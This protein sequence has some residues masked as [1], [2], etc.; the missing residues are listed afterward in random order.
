[1]KYFPTLKNQILTNLTLAIIPTAIFIKFAI[2]FLRTYH[3]LFCK[4]NISSLSYSVT[5]PNIISLSYQHQGSTIPLNTSIK[6]IHITTQSA[7]DTF[8]DQKFISTFAS[9][10]IFLKRRQEIKFESNLKIT[11]L[12]KQNVLNFLKK[13]NHLHFTI[14]CKVILHLFSF[15]FSFNKESTFSIPPP[16]SEQKGTYKVTEICLKNVINLDNPS[17][18]PQKVVT[19][20]D[21]TDIYQQKIINFDDFLTQKNTTPAKSDNTK[22]MTEESERSDKNPNITQNQP[23]NT[24]NLTAECLTS[25]KTSNTTQNQSTK[26]QTENNTTVKTPNTIQISISPNNLQFSPFISLYLQPLCITIN[27]TPLFTSNITI[28]KGVLHPFKIYI[29][30]ISY[31]ISLSII[32]GVLFKRLI[33]NSIKGTLN[34]TIKTLFNNTDITHMI[35]NNTSNTTKRNN[36]N[37][38]YKIPNIR[39]NLHSIKD[40]NI[41]FSTFIHNNIIPL[42]I[43]LITNTVLPPIKYIYGNKN[44]TSNCTY[45]YIYCKDSIKDML[46]S[47]KSNDYKGVNIVEDRLE[48][49]NI[50]EDRLE[51]VNNKDRSEGVSNTSTKQ[52]GVSNKSNE[53]HPVITNTNKQHPVITNTN[54]QHPVINTDI[55]TT[56]FNSV[57]GIGT[58]QVLLYKQGIKINTYL[59]VYSFE[60]LIKKLN[61]PIIIQPICDTPLSLLLSVMS[62]IYKDKTL[63]MFNKPIAS[64]KGNNYIENGNGREIPLVD[65]S[66]VNTPLVEGCVNNTP[67]TDNTGNNTP[68]TDSTGNNT[69]L[70]DSTGYNTPLTDSTDN[71]TPLVDSDVNNTNNHI[72]NNHTNNH[73]NTTTT[74][75]SNT[76][77][78]INNTLYLRTVINIRNNPNIIFTSKNFNIKIYINYFIFTITLRKGII[79]LNK[80]LIYLN[81]KIERNTTTVKYPL[82]NINTGYTSRITYEYVTGVNNKYSDY[83]GVNNSRDDYKGVNNTIN[84][85]SEQQGVNYSSSE[86]QGVNN[87]INSTNE[88]QGV[89]NTINSTNEQQGVNN[90]TT[91]TFID[92]LSQLLDYCNL[93]LIGIE[94]INN[95]IFK[96]CTDTHINNKLK[97]IFNFNKN[98]PNIIFTVNIPSLRFSIEGTEGVICSSGGKVENRVGDVIICNSSNGGV[99]DRDGLEGVNNTT[100]NYKDIKGVSNKD[101]LEGVNNTTNKQQGVS[102]SSNE[103]QSVNNTTNKQQGVSNST[104]KQQG[105]SNS[106]SKQ[107]GVNQSTNKQN[108][109]NTTTN[110]YHPLN[111]TTNKQNPLN[112]T[113]TNSNKKRGVI[114]DTTD[115]DST[116]TISIS[117]NRIKRLKK[118]IIRNKKNKNRS[119]YINRDSSKYISRDSSMYNNNEVYN[120]TNNNSTTKTI[121]TNTSTLAVINTDPLKLLIGCTNNRYWINRKCV[122]GVIRINIIDY[123]KLKG[124]NYISINSLSN[125]SSVSKCIEALFKNMYILV[126]GVNDKDV[127]E[128]DSNSSYEQQGVSNSRIVIIRVL[129]TVV[130]NNRVLVTILINNTPLLPVLINNTPLPL[131]LLPLLHLTIMYVMTVTIIFIKQNIL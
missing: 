37:T 72:N 131:P 129:I 45:D 35:P 123:S 11:S 79:D 51:G 89:N 39:F 127:L 126:K 25:D 49:V 12:N 64:I 10:N 108:P 38:Y 65:S 122:M 100:S 26:T 112:T 116:N 70:T 80:G 75:I 83:R 19:L 28:T 125:S 110:T 6:D 58:L 14:K 120:T 4:Y 92:I 90:T 30:F 94:D 52:H 62:V 77:T 55:L 101:R 67:L 130:M 7:S 121:L 102:N 85:N 82:V 59:T 9:S 118:R 1:M 98:V 103:Q 29:P 105:V 50:V 74:L 114:Y 87:T 111:T 73:T 20:I 33:I 3:L 95:L 18:T 107:Q 97:E 41:V 46:E 53:Q 34:N 69:P 54:K 104:S 5:Q 109:V 40:N 43:S 23:L 128:G 48:G 61:T 106:T 42:D 17:L 27:N 2:V 124:F 81:T 99:N 47:D 24:N 31:K 76:F 8:T 71:N 68:L 63:Y 60:L 32:K 56:P 113:T 91:N 117:K 93:K 21:N 86:Q 44:I 78:C 36:N 115:Y 96:L 88:Q 119:K 66:V 15:E 13:R 84:S 57:Y 22:N 16:A